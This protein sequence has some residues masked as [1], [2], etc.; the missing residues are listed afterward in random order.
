MKLAFNSSNSGLGNNGGTKTIIKCCEALNSIGH[1]CDIITVADKFTWFEHKPPVR[2]M[3]NDLDVIIAVA[4]SDVVGTLRSNVDKKAW[5]IRGHESWSAPEYLLEDYYRNPNILNIVNSKGL[6][7]KLT[8][9]GAD[10]VVVYS[11]IDLGMWEDRRLRYREL[12]Q[13]KIR[14]GCLYN[15]KPT[16]RWE[17]FVELASILGHDDY[18]YVG[19][20][21]KERKDGFLSAFWANI[22]IDE[23]NNVYNSCDIWFAPTELEGLFNVSMEAALCGC[24]II[25]SDAP[26]NG[27]CMDYAFDGDTAMVYEARNIEQ[28]AEIIK[29]P[30]WDLVDKMYDHLVNNISSREVNMKKLVD[31]LEEQL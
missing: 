14:I 20:G 25:C 16:K 3:P 29:N 30:N 22:S 28:A 27:M 4:N 17:D 24:L 11:G 6:Q 19:I 18:E 21:D 31:Y 23:L 12:G 15:G 9:Y 26:M 2:Y 5:Y 8:T 1:E 10:S 13:K 7:Q